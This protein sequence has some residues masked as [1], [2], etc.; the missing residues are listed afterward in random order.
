MGKDQ[1]STVVR[2]KV[3][4][5]SIDHGSIHDF[6]TQHKRTKTAQENP[7]GIRYEYRRGHRCGITAE[8]DSSFSMFNAQPTTKE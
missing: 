5:N 8:T 4:H 2:V 3:V 1:T 7:T 6:S